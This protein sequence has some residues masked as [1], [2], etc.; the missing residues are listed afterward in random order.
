MLLNPEE[1]RQWLWEFLHNHA[2]ALHHCP[3]D[4]YRAMHE[5][6]LLTY[7]GLTELG[8]CLIRGTDVQE[9]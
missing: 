1:V 2:T 9:A 8:Q 6:G 5:M 4:V 3:Q 7:H